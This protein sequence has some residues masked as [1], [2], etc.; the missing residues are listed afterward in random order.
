MR[1]Q[2]QAALGQ[3]RIQRDRG[4][5]LGAG[6]PLRQRAAQ[7]AGLGLLDEL[8]LQAAHGAPLPERALRLRALV[9]ASGKGVGMAC[10]SS[11]YLTSGSFCEQAAEHPALALKR[12]P[13]G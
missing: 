8:R 2:Q 5:A 1:R 3:A 12:L 4:H 10:L 6:L 7:Q 9:A 11:L 13:P